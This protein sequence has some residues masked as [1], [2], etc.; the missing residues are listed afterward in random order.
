MAGKK[1][2]FAVHSQP[3]LPFCRFI[4]ICVIRTF[5]DPRPFF[6]HPGRCPTFEVS[7]LGI[8]LFA[9]WADGYRPA[10]CDASAFRLRCSCW[11]DVQ[12]WPAFGREPGDESQCCLDAALVYKYLE[13]SAQTCPKVFLENMCYIDTYYPAVSSGDCS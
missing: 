5:L 8:F 13:K 11:P 2:K 3:C 6:L 9:H 10:G 12:P 7:G 1:R 4:I